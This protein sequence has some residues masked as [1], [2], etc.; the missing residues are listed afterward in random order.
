[1]IAKCILLVLLLAGCASNPKTPEG[2]RHC[3]PT[4][5]PVTDHFKKWGA[6]DAGHTLKLESR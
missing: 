3:G 6:A 2:C 5:H 1:M 4:P